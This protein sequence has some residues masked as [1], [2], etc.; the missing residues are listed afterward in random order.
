MSGHVMLASAR[1]ESGTFVAV[2]T[3][4]KTGLTPRQLQS[5]RREVDIYLRMD[6]Q[7]IVKLLRVFDEQ[8]RI[9]LVMEHCAGGSLAERLHQRGHFSAHGSID[10]VRQVLSAVSYCHSRPG[11]AVCHRD[12]KLANFVYVDDGEVLKL[13]DFGLSRVL[14]PGG[15]LQNTAGTLDF[16]APEVLLRK[17][18][19]ES[20][21]MWSVGVITCCLL[22]GQK[23]FSGNTEV[24]VTGAIMRGRLELDSEA[25][26]GVSELAKEFIRKL[27]RLCPADRLTAS[28]ALRHPWLAAKAA[29]PVEIVLPEEVSEEVLQ[30]VRDFAL[31]SPA[32]RAAAALLVYADGVPTGEEFERAEAQFRKLD[33]DG[34]GTLSAAELTG[35]LQSTLG[36]SQEEGQQI[37][38]SIDLVRDWEIERSEFMAAAMCKHLSSSESAIRKA[39]DC[40]DLDGNGTISPA[41]LTTVIGRRFCGAPAIQIFREWDID[42]REAISY[43][44]FKAVLRKRRR[45]RTTP[46][47]EFQRVRHSMGELCE[48]HPQY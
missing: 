47:A 48:K 28:A 10:A 1:E 16:M 2:K 22:T 11:G 9:Y 40:L 26:Q 36:V 13:V 18:H 17:G 29:R 37:F 39:F 3:L 12:L 45:P 46:A 41:E 25:W 33:T 15:Q 21:D 4:D 5:L 20:C 14:A 44:Q 32:K 24:E 6:H 23:P 35:P 31:E 8:D 27:I 43:D 38:D 30:T 42:G 19:T 7:H 34:N